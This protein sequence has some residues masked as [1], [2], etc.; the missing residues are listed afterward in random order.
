MTPEAAERPRLARI[1]GAEKSN[2]V[3]LERGHQVD[4]DVPPL[5]VE[6]PLSRLE[7]ARQMIGRG[8]S[9]ES[10]IE[11]LIISCRSV[12]LSLS[13]VFQGN[14]SLSGYLL[15]PPRIAPCYAGYQECA[16]YA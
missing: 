8:D 16:H 1:R 9:L 3:R 10:L 2:R 14:H 12:S 11:A 5:A 4:E 13:L 6:I 7:E 15:L